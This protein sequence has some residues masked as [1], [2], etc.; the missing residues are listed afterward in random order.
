MNSLGN[1]TISSRMRSAL[2]ILYYLFLVGLSAWIVSSRIFDLE[3]APPGLFFD[4]SSIGYNAL[5][6]L[7]TGHDEHGVLFPVYFKS[8][9]DYKNPVY[10]YAVALVFSL[11]GASEFTL[12]FT[13]VLFFLGALL[14]S[15]LLIWRMFRRSALPTIYGAAA[16]GFTPL[17]FVLSRISFEVISQLTV[18]SAAILMIWEAFNRSS[19][20]KKWRLYSFTG[21][22]LLGLSTYCYTTQRLLSGLTLF[23][24]WAVYFDRKYIKKLL[25][26]STGFALMMIPL[27]AFSI[28]SPGSVTERFSELSYIDDPIR[29]SEKA[30]IF[31]QNYGKYWSPEFLI[32]RGDPNLRHSTGYGGV[33]FVTI[34]ALFVLGFPAL[35]A[36][37]NRNRFSS[38]IAINL[39]LSPVAAAL[40]TEGA[41]HALRSMLMVYYIIVISCNSLEWLDSSSRKGPL[42]A[43]VLSVLLLSLLF[44][45]VRYQKDY[46]SSYPSRSVEAFGSF[47]FK[48]A[49]EFS[50]EQQPNRI[51]AV[52]LP[53]GGYANVLFY[54]ELVDNPGEV[55]ILNSDEFLKPVPGMCILFHRR[56]DIEGRLEEYSIP[57]ENFS[58]RKKLS[59]LEKWL[60]AEKFGGVIRVRCY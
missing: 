13:S 39:V 58:S 14:F 44:E 37:R 23:A 26:F 20:D 43:A 57:Y 17:F 21:G 32:L 51:A 47:D 12:R 55:P 56:T 34:L 41:P 5:S 50:L 6:I 54:S 25:L 46:F 28:A 4:E 16:F 40:I 36:K 59:P 8:V 49:L 27:M 48:S 9:G 42:K 24:L 33:L 30:F 2:K 60:H 3:A 29:F 22:I 52:G 18:V 35:F 31:L 10:I 15:T 11:F 53:P 19:D 38:F 45:T 1:L 7:K